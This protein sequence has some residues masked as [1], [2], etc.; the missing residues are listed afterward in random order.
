MSKGAVLIISGPSGCGK[1]TLTQELLRVIPNLYFS[2]STTT[3]AMRQ[4]EQDGVHYHFV[5]EQEFLTQVQEGRFLEWAQVH[6]NYYGTSL[7]PI[8]RALEQG[9]I[10]LFDVDVQ[11]HRDIK[12]HFG[13]FAQSVFITTK[14]K[15]ILKSRLQSRQTDDEHTIEFRLIQAYEEMQHLHTFD[16]VLINDDITQAKQAITAIAQSLLYRNTRQNEE[17]LQNWSKL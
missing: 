6:N 11:G 5:S 12:A 1:S 7:E 4:G 2:I 14:N 9:K 3:R 8:T 13:D 10:V 17:L 16:Y 15:E